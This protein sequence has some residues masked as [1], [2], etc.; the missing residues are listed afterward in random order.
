MLMIYETKLQKHIRDSCAA[1]MG[2]AN[3]S[4]DFIL[5]T[6]EEIAAY[7]ARKDPRY[8][9]SIDQKNPQQNPFKFDAS[10]PATTAWNRRC[11][12]VFAEHYVAL[13]NARTK[14]Q[15]VV[16]RAITTHHKALHLQWMNRNKNKLPSSTKQK[17]ICAKIRQKQ[18]SRRKEVSQAVS[19][20]S[21]SPLTS[22]LAL[23]ASTWGSGDAQRQ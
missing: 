5:P 9:P 16:R 15:N 13:S 21:L 18:Y 11:I 20:S 8:G 22:S 6:E 23:H 2:R 7:E 4:A 14:D 10:R 12:E 17:M 1:W 3:N 19:V